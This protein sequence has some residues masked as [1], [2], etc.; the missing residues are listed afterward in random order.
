MSKKH[1]QKH[2]VVG[3]NGDPCPRCRKPTEIREHTEITAKHLAQPFFYERWFNCVNPACK[4]TLIMP[5]RYRVFASEATREQYADGPLFRQP[6]RLHDG[7]DAVMDV[8]N[9]VQ[10]PDPHERPPWE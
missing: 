9:T 2:K 8:L 3:M 1:K 6:D 4:T 10:E 5:D 7:D